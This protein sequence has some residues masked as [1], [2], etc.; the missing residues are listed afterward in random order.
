MSIRSSQ[1]FSVLRLPVLAS[2]I[3]LTACATGYKPKGALGDGYSE[4]RVGTD[5]WMVTFDASVFTP[6]ERM[7]AYLLWRC[8]EI[9]LDHRATYFGIVNDGKPVHRSSSRPTLIDKPP[10]P[11]DTAPSEPEVPSGRS[12]RM[13]IQLYPERPDSV[14]RYYEARTIL[15]RLAPLMRGK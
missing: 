1:L 5:V 4:Q 9:T 13:T 3:A 11:T 6:R 2:L 15:Q 12:A 7:D 10:F 14:D 8:A